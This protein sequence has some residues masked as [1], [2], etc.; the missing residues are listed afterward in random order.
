M[1]PTALFGP[2][3]P[4]SARCIILRLTKNGGFF[5]SKRNRVPRSPGFRMPCIATCLPPLLWQRWHLSAQ[6][7][8]GKIIGSIINTRG[9][10]HNEEEHFPSGHR[11]G[12]C[13]CAVGVVGL[14]AEEI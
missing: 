13:G 5:L 11:Y 7:S 1:T 8:R 2:M 14:R 6:R 12:A 4:L 3:H 10:Q 9:T